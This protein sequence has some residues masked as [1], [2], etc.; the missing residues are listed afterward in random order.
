MKYDKEAVELKIQQALVQIV[1]NYPFYATILYRLRRVEDHT[2]PTAWTDGRYLGYNPAFIHSLTK[3]EV[4]GVM[5]HEVLHVAAMHPYRT[6]T[7]DPR[8][9]N[10]ACFPPGTWTGFGK[11]IEE[12][13]TM[14]N[15]FNGELV[16]VDSQG[17]RVEATPEH[18]FLVRR[19]K[20]AAY[21]IKLTEPEWI[22]AAELRVGDYV[23]VPNT[24]I[25]R[26]DTEI[27]LSS[28]IKEGVDG[29]GR[30][31]FGNRAIK[32]IPLNE[33]TA[34]LIGVYVAEGSGPTVAFTLGQHELAFAGRVQQVLADCGIRS[35][36]SL[37]AVH[38]GKSVKV[39]SGNVVFLRWL[40]EHCGRNARTKCI[41]RVI[42]EH[43][44]PAIRKAF[45]K[46]LMQG[47]GYL[48]TRGKARIWTLGT[49]SERLATD[50]LELLAQDG[51]GGARHVARRG[52]RKLRDATLPPQVLHVVTWNRDGWTSKPRNLNGKMIQS[53]NHQWRP[54][55]VGVWYPVRE[56]SRRPYAGPVYNLSTPSHTYTAGGALV[57]NCDQVVNS[58]VTDEKLVLPKGC[59]PGVPDKAAEELYIDPPPGSGQGDG[60]DDPGGCGGVR[61]P[62][63]DDGSALSDAQREQAM[64]ETKVMVQQALTAAKKAGQLP[65]G[66]KRFAEDLL[67]PKV[68][69]KE[70]MSRFV[71][72][73]SRHDYSWSRPNKRYASA[74][75]LL[76]SL[77]SPA[78]GEIVMG[79]DT[80]GS[81]DQAQLKEVCS[82]VLGALDCY[83]ERGQS[84]ELTVAWFDHAVYTQ[85]VSE[86]EE[87]QPQGGGGTSF[88]V[89]MEWL[90]QDRD[91]MPKALIMVTDGYCGD[92]GEDPGIPVLWVLTRTNREFTPPFGELTCTLNED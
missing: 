36:Q 86:A 11:P 15:P 61:A 54:D 17:P 49:A 25:K 26:Q 80:S 13:A 75:L 28:Y 79:C 2:R 7:R 51:I 87:L 50:V 60:S 21:P 76:P 1:C 70:V 83:A 46:G 9:W 8:A 55:V 47:D 71:D 24:P 20:S 72:S 84:P 31:T 19:R 27:D 68:P 30:R 74:G 59:I 63:N 92:F 41:P 5:C 45:L 29:K 64:Q 81:I 44:D 3:D 88:R 66:L 48:Q 90:V 40:K 73:H 39:C 69:W 12:V 65:A 35:S 4:V 18:P 62:T 37:P 82:E 67:E 14:A 91:A 57:H 34:W 42:I 32:S 6:G 10:I 56:V 89:V 16:V 33:D 52:P 78:Y 22:E 38:R 58:I 77:H 85:V 53:R 43:A 23:L